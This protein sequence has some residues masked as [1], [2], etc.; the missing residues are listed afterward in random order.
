MSI[1]RKKKPRTFSGVVEI[2]RR[3]DGRFSIT[4]PSEGGRTFVVANEIKARILEN[5]ERTIDPNLHVVWADQKTH[6]LTLAKPGRRATT[7]G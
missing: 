6:D 1:F 2:R 7:R 3:D 5:A 4:L